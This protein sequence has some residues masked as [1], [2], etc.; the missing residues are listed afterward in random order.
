MAYMTMV[1]VT[2][3]ESFYFYNLS[4]SPNIFAVIDSSA[5]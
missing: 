2:I 4:S 1:E 3:P 5:W